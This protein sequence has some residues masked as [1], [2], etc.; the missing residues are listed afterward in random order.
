[1][2]FVESALFPGAVAGVADLLNEKDFVAGTVVPDL[3][4]GMAPGDSSFSLV[5]G[6]GTELPTDNFVVTIEQEIIFVGSRTGD[7]CSS[8]IRGFQGTTPSSH[9]GG[10][11]VNHFI[12]AHHHNRVVAEINSI[13]T[14]LSGSTAPSKTLYVD[15]NRAGGYT[16]DGT[17]LRPFK[18]IMA[19]V[20]QIITNGDNSTVPYL[21]DIAAGIYL[22]TIDLSNSKIVNIAFDGHFQVTVGTTGQ[23]RTAVQAINNDNLV[24]AFF[25]RMAFIGG[26]GVTPFMQFSS[27]TNGTNFGSIGIFFQECTLQSVG[28]SSFTVNNCGF[29]QWDDCDVT[30]NEITITNCG[31]MFVFVTVVNGGSALSV[32]T[33]SGGPQPAGFFS[34]EVLFI[35]GLMAGTSVMDAGSEI[36][37]E[38]VQVIGDCTANGLLKARTSRIFGNITVNSGGTYDENGGSGHTGTVTVNS[39]GSYTQTGD[40][41]IGTLH[42][43]ATGKLG[44]YGTSPQ[45]KQTVTGSKGGNAALA[46]LLTALSTLGLITDS[47]T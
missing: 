36:A 4:S 43:S 35:G 24:S 23:I 46:S 15:G 45:A 34:T 22:E 5:T 9:G 25:D 28:V 10:T 41:G 14:F 1:M 27:T 29:V 3:A 40:F 38:G 39:G 18:T 42:H 31:Q 17:I 47:S 11:M 7:V 37:F 13:E 44:F 16:P 33:N 8:L 32:V 26:G 21:V 20:N 12:I 2:P 6:T 19:A 30:S